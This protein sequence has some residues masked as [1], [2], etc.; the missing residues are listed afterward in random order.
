MAIRVQQDQISRIV[1]AAFTPWNPMVNVPPRLLGDQ[2][3]TQC[4]TLV[5]IP[6]KTQKLDLALRVTLHLQTE[7]IFEVRLPLRV[8]GIGFALYLGVSADSCV[9]RFDERHLFPF[10]IPPLAV[11]AGT[12]AQ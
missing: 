5:L 3:V 1:W 12:P 2:L 7:S 11:Q 10:F 9:A 6:P 8:K 4:T